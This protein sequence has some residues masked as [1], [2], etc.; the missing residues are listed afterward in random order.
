[1]SEDLRHFLDR[2]R[3]FETTLPKKQPTK[4][5]GDLDNYP[6]DILP[7]DVYRGKRTNITKIGDQ[8][9]KAYY[10]GVWDGCAVLMR[11]LIEM[12][13]VLAFKEHKIENEIISSD[14]KYFELS[15]IINAAKSNRILDLS[16]KTKEYLEPF[17]DKGNLS[18]H[19]I[20]YNAVK[21]DLELVQPMFRPL[22]EELLYKAGIIK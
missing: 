7:F 16:Q 17:R 21:K 3:K 18:A 6:D 13:L 8:I 22:V 4:K 5:G 15:R 9:N 1:M 11:R 10:Y 19:H 14:G 20:F 2:L 12:L